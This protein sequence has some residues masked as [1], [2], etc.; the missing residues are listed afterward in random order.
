MLV[1]IRSNIW[2]NTDVCAEH[3]RC[4]TDLYL[5]SILSQLYDIIIDRGI[6]APV[7]IRYFADGLNDTDK[8]FI[9]H[10]MATFQL[11]GSKRFMHKCK[12][13]QKHEI[14]T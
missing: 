1:S 12:C 14:F 5:F 6:S 7:K 2:D 11:P 13:T 8:I 9:F 3:Y 10:M 4:D